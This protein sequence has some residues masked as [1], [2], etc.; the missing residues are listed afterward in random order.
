MILGLSYA[1]FVGII[2]TTIL[3]GPTET[4]NLDHVGKRDVVVTFGT[5]ATSKSGPGHDGFVTATLK[6]YDLSFGRFTP[7]YAIG[8]SVDGAIFASAGIGKRFDF[9]GA[10]IVPHWSPTLYQRNIENG[11]SQSE[12]IQFRTGFD[13]SFEV[14]KDF[15]VNGGFYHIS[16]AGIT[17]KSA[18]IDVSHLGMKFRF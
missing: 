14:M 10:E 4:P 12:L 15:Y 1:Q 17:S 16:N 5:N 6:P 11:F 8:V 18:G 13:I 2:G 3:F 9:F 7:I